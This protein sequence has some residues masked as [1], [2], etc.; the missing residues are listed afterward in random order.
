[1][2][3]P[4]IFLVAARAGTERGVTVTGEDL[5]LCYAGEAVAMAS[6]RQQR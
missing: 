5:G 6:C 4:Q 1:M 2:R 3:L